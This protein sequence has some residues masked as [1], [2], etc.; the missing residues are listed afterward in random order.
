[1]LTSDT[2][3]FYERR[4][5]SIKLKL[6]RCPSKMRGLHLF[7]C[8]MESRFFFI[9]VFLL[10]YFIRTLLK[11][12]FCRFLPLNEVTLISSTFFRSLN[13]SYCNRKNSKKLSY[14]LE[15]TFRLCGFYIESIQSFTHPLIRNTQNWL[16]NPG[17]KLAWLPVTAFSC[18]SWRYEDSIFI[19]LN[20]S[21]TYS[22]LIWSRIKL[23]IINKL[24]SFTFPLTRPSQ[25]L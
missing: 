12:C 9:V 14:F 11:E 23:V 4:K 5:E 15:Q 24:I 8:F 16:R 21:L 22:R 6:F 13:D 20:F 3:G 1:M 7:L 25:S 2:L 17:L 10:F 19:V 18:F